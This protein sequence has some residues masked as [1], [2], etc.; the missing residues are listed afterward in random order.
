M[1]V[2]PAS[3]GSL[4][5]LRLLYSSYADVFCD[6]LKKSKRCLLYYSRR[7]EQVPGARSGP[8][9]ACVLTLSVVQT[10]VSICTFMIRCD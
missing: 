2:A 5:A 7:Q 6:A 10:V 9:A 1:W 4:A 8:L 3:R